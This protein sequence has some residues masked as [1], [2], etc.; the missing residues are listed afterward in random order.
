MLRL[1]WILPCALGAMAVFAY[2]PSG[3]AAADLDCS[4]FSSQAEAQENLLPGDPYGLDG[5]SDGIACEDLPCPCAAGGESGGGNTGA[6]PPPPPPPPKLDKA[7]ARSA[8]ERK[9]RKFTR[10]RSSLDS[11]VLVRCG[12]RGRQR[13]VCR[14]VASGRN[15]TQQTTCRFRVVVRGE[16]RRAAATIRGVRCR[17]RLLPVLSP[18]RAKRAMDA[19][20]RQIA[21]TRV[22]VYALSRIGPRSFSGLAEWLQK[23]ASGAE[24]LC[25]LE[26][27]AEQP[28]AQPIRVRTRNLDCQGI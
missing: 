18:A 6:E 14:F 27:E 19:A 20:V 3:A 8:A 11:V 24:E 17:S 10:R 9:A 25:S 21:R 2:A 7:A 23:S 16:E 22:T 13:V 12:R 28:P 26:L 15:D 5:D 1:R 4:D